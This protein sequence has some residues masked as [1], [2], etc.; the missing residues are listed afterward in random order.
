MNFKQIFYLLLF[1][2]IIG[3]IFYKFYPKNEHVIIKKEKVKEKVKEKEK[4]SS[5]IIV[6]LTTSPK[7]I[8]LME[9]TLNS[10]LNQTHQPHLIRINIPKQFKRTGQ[11]YDIPD[12]IKNNSKIQI[13]QYEEDYGPIMKILPTFLDYKDH[14]NVNIIYIDDDV[15]MLPNAIETFVKYININPNFVYCLS[16]F[17]FKGSDKWIRNTNQ[18]CFVN[19]PEGY[20]S[21]CLS[22]VVLNKIK[23]YSI[24]EYYNL[25]SKN[26]YCFTSDDLMIGNFLEMNNIYIYKIYDDKANFNLWWMSGCE[27]PYGKSGDGIMHLGQDQHFTR[28][29][30]ALQYLID[31]KMNFFT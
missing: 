4:D 5:I 3:F 23:N 31:N 10:I 1:T 25:F 15:L 24:E 20:M 6:S 22:N 11:F 17:D 26:E 8:K 30:K 27:L 12:F 2:L 29:N 16:G 18:S 13:F 7:R 19:I 28:Y 14:P 21:V 9:N